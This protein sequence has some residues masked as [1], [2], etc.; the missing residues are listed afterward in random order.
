MCEKNL[1]EVTGNKSNP[2]K[3]SS[4]SLLLT[5]PADLPENLSFPFACPQNG[6]SGLVFSSSSSDLGVRL[7][8][9]SDS[10]RVVQERDWVSEAKCFE[11][12]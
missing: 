2:R 4:A 1:Y 6:N 11:G 7:N 9:Y 5:E 10:I 8:T 12:A 3:L